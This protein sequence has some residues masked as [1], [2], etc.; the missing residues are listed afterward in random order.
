M[1]AGEPDHDVAAVPLVPGH[2]DAAA[3]EHA[4]Q[5]QLALLPE[6]IDAQR[7]AVMA[8]RRLGAIGPE[9]S[10]PP[11]QL[12]PKLLSG[13]WPIG[14]SV[15]VEAL[16]AAPSNIVTQLLGEAKYKT[17]FTL[18]YVGAHLGYELSVMVD[19]WRSLLRPPG[20]WRN[21]PA[22]L[23]GVSCTRGEGYRECS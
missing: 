3:A 14:G 20:A 23:C 9:Q 8:K 2:R 21:L 13:F 18:P 12:K 22:R 1:P 7:H 4:I 17:E 16:C 11:G 19:V 6:E 10:I 5:P 15:A